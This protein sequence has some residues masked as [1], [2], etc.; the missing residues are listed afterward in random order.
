[1]DLRIM[2]VE[3]DR[4]VACAYGWTE[5]SLGHDFHETEQGLR[6]S[7]SETARRTVLDLLLSL[8]H[9]L[10]AEE[11]SQPTPKPI[12][13]PERRRSKKS[14]RKPDSDQYCLIKG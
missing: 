11:S 7:M 13:G 4:A 9:Q 6:Y 12:L 1:V 5:L 14:G 3:M 8:N 10:Y 2:H